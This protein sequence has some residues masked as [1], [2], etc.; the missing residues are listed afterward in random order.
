MALNKKDPDDPTICR[1]GFF[2][3]IDLSYKEGWRIRSFVSEL[4]ENR[5]FCYE[6]GLTIFINGHWTILKLWYTYP[7][8][9]TCTGPVQD[10]AD[11]WDDVRAVDGM[12]VRL[13]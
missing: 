8:R 10:F 7:K 9:S 4:P 3:V 11:K 1:V 6:W 2:G 5:V 13:I 12:S